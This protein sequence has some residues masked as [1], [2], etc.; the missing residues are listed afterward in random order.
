M[1]DWASRT[2]ARDL[3]A[4][5]REHL[6]LLKEERD[7][8]VKDKH[9][10]DMF[11]RLN[12]WMR[13]QIDSCNRKLGEKKYSVSLVN[14][15]D[16]NRKLEREFSVIRTD[17]SKQPLKLTYDPTVH[18]LRCESS[19][20]H[21]EYILTVDKDGQPRFESLYHQ[22]KTIEEIGTELLDSWE[23]APF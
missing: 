11:Q 2:A 17:G 14:E 21:Q 12:Q 3:E 15:P 22:V 1:E 9:G 5:D 13:D 8:Q 6:H 19:A 4:Q 20:G 7:S 16:F 23:A 18:R 10:I